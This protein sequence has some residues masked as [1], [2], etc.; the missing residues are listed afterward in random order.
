MRRRK[1]NR[2]I[3][4]GKERGGNN[5]KFSSVSNMTFHISFFDFSVRFDDFTF[6]LVARFIL[7]SAGGHI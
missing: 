5:E 3:K 6:C 2:V 4:K 1:R 7:F